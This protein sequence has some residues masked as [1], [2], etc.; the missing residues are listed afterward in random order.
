MKSNYTAKELEEIKKDCWGCDCH[1]NKCEYHKE[2]L[3]GRIDRCEWR[4]LTHKLGSAHSPC[5]WTPEIMER[6]S[7]YLILKKLG[8]RK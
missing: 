6:I 3:P 4:D 1:H 8:M 5:F 7:Q 2:N